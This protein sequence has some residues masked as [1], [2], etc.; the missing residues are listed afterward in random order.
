MGCNDYLY[1][2]GTRLGCVAGPGRVPD[3]TTFV[4]MVSPV[5]WRSRVGSA[6]KGTCTLTL[7]RGGCMAGVGAV[8]VNGVKTGDHDSLLLRP[9]AL[10]SSRPMEDAVNSQFPTQEM[11]E[12]KRRTNCEFAF[13]HPPS[14]EQRCTEDTQQQYQTPEDQAGYSCGRELESLS[15]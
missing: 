10:L 7:G 8:W 15:R 11:K 1:A 4:E 2:G 9:V 13:S 6:F 3:G 14:I 5:G 12:T